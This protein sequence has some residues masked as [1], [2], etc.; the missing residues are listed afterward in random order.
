M[1]NGHGRF[2]VLEG[3][4]GAG[5]TTQ[6]RLLHDSLASEGL[7]C[8]LT[9]EPTDSA[10]GILIREALSHRLVSHDTQ[11]KLEFSE[12]V[13]CLLFAADRLDHRRSIESHR[14]DGNHVVCDRYVHSSIAYQAR[15]RNIS[16]ER[17]IGVNAGISTPD[18]TFFLRVPVDVCLARLEQRNDTPTVYEKKDLLVAI[19]KNY[20]ATLDLYVK[21]YGP[22]IEIDG[23]QPAEVVHAAVVEKLRDYL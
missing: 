17:V 4:D 11:Q 14:D 23:T 3:L 20:D 12:D 16:A 1:S 15:D 7:P 2:I 19:E 5:T 6:S 13:L 10:V 18:I 21:H 9:R 22:V 8:H